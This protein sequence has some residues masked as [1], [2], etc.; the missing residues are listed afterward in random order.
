MNKSIEIT[1]TL[2]SEEEEIL[3]PTAL[4]LLTL[5]HRQLNS[6]RLELL[7]QRKQ[8]QSEL[9]DGRKPDFLMNFK[10]VVLK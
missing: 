5:L 7:K 10:I 6:R 2:S 9:D 8:N 1:P 4:Q 3:N